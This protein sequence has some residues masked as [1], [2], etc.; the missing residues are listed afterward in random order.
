[1]TCE[2]LTVLIKDIVIKAA[3]L[4]NRFIKE[5]TAPV[6]YA[7]LFSQSQEEYQSLKPEVN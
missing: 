4:K 7:C 2:N 6:N 1:M 5:K 3:I